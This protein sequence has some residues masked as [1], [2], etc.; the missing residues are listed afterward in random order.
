MR[1]VGEGVANVQNG[2]CLGGTA[3][4]DHM[5]SLSRDAYVESA[6]GDCMLVLLGTSNS[7]GS[8]RVVYIYH[9]EV[10]RLCT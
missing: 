7:P 4:R 10:R 2:G 5:A 3:E 6:T 1:A 9:T 8:R